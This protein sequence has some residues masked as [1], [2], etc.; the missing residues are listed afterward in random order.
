MKTCN[1]CGGMRMAFGDVFAGDLKLCSCN[2]PEVALL[3][4]KIEELEKENKQIIKHLGDTRDICQRLED[5]ITGLEEKV[6]FVMEV[7]NEETFLRNALSD[8]KAEYEKKLKIADDR[9]N[10]VQPE[11]LEP[12]KGESFRRGFEMGKREA[13]EEIKEKLPS[14]KPILHVTDDGDGYEIDEE[15]IS[16]TD[17]RFNS[18]LKDITDLLNTL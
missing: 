14:S 11:E 18:C 10:E 3:S 9:W 5:R 4:Q 7:E 8:Q 17:E 1:I 2:Q 12:H 6:D 13:V 15:Y 16:D